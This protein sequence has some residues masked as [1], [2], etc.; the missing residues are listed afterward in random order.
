[1]LE[2]KNTNGYK[3]ALNKCLNNGLICGFLNIK[4]QFIAHEV[5]KLLIAMCFQ[6]NLF[7]AISFLNTAS[8]NRVVQCNKFC[9]YEESLTCWFVFLLS[10]F[11]LVSHSQITRL[12]SRFTSLDKGENGTL[13]WVLSLIQL[14]LHWHISVM[15]ACCCRMPCMFS[16]YGESVRLL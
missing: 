7:C 12:Y 6:C 5:P 13:R 3:A 15:V 10:I 8:G 14:S 4:M 9:S 16:S 1:M 2:T 11:F